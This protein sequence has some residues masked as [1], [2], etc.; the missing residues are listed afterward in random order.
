PINL[1]ANINLS[2]TV[3]W[4]RDA[5]ARTF[6]EMLL[7]MKNAQPDSPTVMG[8]RMRSLPFNYY[9]FRNNGMLSPI[10][11]NGYRSDE[12]DYQIGYLGMEADWSAYDTLF[13]HTESDLYL[14]GRKVKRERKIIFTK[15]E[16][17]EEKTGQEFIEWFGEGIDTLNGKD[18]L[19]DIQIEMPE[20]IGPFEAWVSVALDDMD[21][22]QI[23]QEKIV[24]DWLR[25]SWKK[26]DVFNY[27]MVMPNIPEEAKYMK[28]FFWNIHKTPIELGVVKITLFEILPDHKNSSNLQ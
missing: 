2:H 11:S 1:L 27:Y 23:A 26:G 22:K 10:Q 15:E 17:K 6:Y 16:R 28:V 24:L 9:N 3:L 12:A 14:M 7:N 25:P 20:I 21:H 13:H 8:Y 19:W 4:D 5:S 18:L